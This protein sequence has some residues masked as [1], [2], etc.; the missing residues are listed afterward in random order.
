MLPPGLENGD[1]DDDGGGAGLLTLPLLALIGACWQ[2][3]PR[4]N[5]PQCTQGPPS[6]T[7]T[8]LCIQPW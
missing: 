4:P 1:G 6:L 3:W 2:L 7:S 5:Y 8:V